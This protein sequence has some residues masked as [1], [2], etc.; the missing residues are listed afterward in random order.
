MW[1]LTL[2]S[3]YVTV[4]TYVSGK[5]CKISGRY[6]RMFIMEKFAIKER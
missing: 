5:Q 1:K 6:D 3:G 4:T 2:F